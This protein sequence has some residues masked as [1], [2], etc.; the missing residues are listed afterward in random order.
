MNLFIQ[1]SLS[2]MEE[3][4]KEPCFMERNMEKENFSSKMEP[5]IKDSSNKTKW[6]AMELYFTENDVQHTKVNGP[7]ISSMEEVSFTTNL[8]TIWTV[9]M[10]IET[11]LKSKSSG[12]DTKV[13][14]SLLRLV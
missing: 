1:F 5:T 6:M 7:T 2:K 8:L 3:A 10:T 12:L 13:N 11:W 4:M 9:N 14:I